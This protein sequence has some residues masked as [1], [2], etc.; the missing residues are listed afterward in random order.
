MNRNVR[1]RGFYVPHFC[2]HIK[3]WLVPQGAGSDEMESLEELITRR[4]GITQSH[5]FDLPHATDILHGN[6]ALGRCC[7][8]CNLWAYSWLRREEP[9]VCRFCMGYGHIQVIRRSRPMWRFSQLGNLKWMHKGCEETKRHYSHSIGILIPL[10][11]L[12]SKAQWLSSHGFT[13]SNLIHHVL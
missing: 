8:G 1:K 11:A 9:F 3:L 7:R 2:L 10:L 5:S 6:H 12:Y 4:F 13:Y